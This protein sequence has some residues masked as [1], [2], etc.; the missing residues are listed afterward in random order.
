M[1]TVILACIEL[2]VP[3]SGIVHTV[4]AEWQKGAGYVVRD[5]IGDGMPRVYPSAT[6]AV[7]AA[8]GRAARIARNEF[9]TE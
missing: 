5:S 8:C 7:S 9:P 6:A 3:G 4:R 2:R 1:S